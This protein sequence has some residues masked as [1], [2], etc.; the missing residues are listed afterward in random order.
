MLRP[1]QKKIE[2]LL[3]AQLANKKREKNPKP[4]TMQFYCKYGKWSN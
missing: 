1:N 3:A 4:Y 2:I